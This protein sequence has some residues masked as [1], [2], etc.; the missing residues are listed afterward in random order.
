MMTKNYLTPKERVIRWLVYIFLTLIIVYLLAPNL[1][2]IVM[3]FNKSKYL[4]FPITELSLKWFENAVTIPAWRRAFLNS[5]VLALLTATASTVIGSLAALGVHHSRG[6]MK[7]MMTSFFLA[8]MAI[9]QLLLGIALLL[10]LGRFGLTGSML[11]LFLGHILVTV[12]YVIRMVLAG[13][14]TVSQNIEEAAYTLGADE[15]TTLMKITL[16]NIK[17]SV[18][19][20]ALF[21]FILSFDNLMI[22]LFLASSKVNTIPVKIL[23]TLEWEMDP[24]VAAVSAIFMV[25]TFSIMLILQKTVGLDFVGISARRAEKEQ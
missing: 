6:K 25:L 24:T 21:A 14:P 8:P 9:P 22:S 1:A 23:E 4:Q 12:P 15:I 20:G 19:S 3:S 11:A 7:D 10:V 17:S 13:L 5:L 16:P 2:V 18:I